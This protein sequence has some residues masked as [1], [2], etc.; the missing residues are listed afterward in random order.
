MSE[1]GWERVRRVLRL[2]SSPKR[3]QADVDAELRFHVDGRIEDLMRE[4]LS[5]DEA[6]REAIRRFGDV[7]E[8]RRQAHMIDQAMHSKRGRMELL[9]VIG[10]EAR[11]AIR[12]LR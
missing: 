11:H 9:D 1:R 6:E 10:R 7:D 12:M 5:R 3:I 4:G 8:Y 2:P